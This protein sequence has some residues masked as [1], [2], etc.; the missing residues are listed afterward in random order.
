MLAGGVITAATGPRTIEEHHEEEGGEEG[1]IGVLVP[2]T[3]TAPSA[4]AVHRR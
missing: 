1:S 2:Q 4:I 3:G